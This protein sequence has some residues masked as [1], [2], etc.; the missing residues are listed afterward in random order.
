MASWH[1]KVM[2]YVLRSQV[3]L[4]LTSCVRVTYEVITNVV[5][6]NIM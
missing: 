4:K 6:E 2:H 3:A 5:N 1:V